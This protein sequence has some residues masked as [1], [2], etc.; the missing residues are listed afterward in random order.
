M[1]YTQDSLPVYSS[2]SVPLQTWASLPLQTQT[3]LDLPV[4]TDLSLQQ[5]TACSGPVPTAPVTSGAFDYGKLEYPVVQGQSPSGHQVPSGH[6]PEPGHRAEA[7][8]RPER[9]HASTSV[10]KPP[11]P[12]S[13]EGMSMSPEGLVS[14]E[15]HSET[16]VA[17][18]EEVGFGHATSS[19]RPMASAPD[20]ALKVQT[21]A[22]Q[23]FEHMMS[24]LYLPDAHQMYS[25]GT[26]QMQYSPEV[27]A[28]KQNVG[29]VVALDYI[30]Y[31]RQIGHE[32]MH[33]D[34]GI[35]NTHWNH[36]GPLLQFHDGNVWSGNSKDIEQEAALQK[37]D[38]GE[39]VDLR[40]LRVWKQGASASRRRGPDFETLNKLR[41]S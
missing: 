29:V 25:Y 23:E 6:R 41:N 40:G 28:Q 21:K 38:H 14:L 30:G 15:P 33:S 2:A 7:R 12:V 36:I 13:R 10:P 19:T 26:R 20:E 34:D 22:E 37:S 17:K 9:R 11:K 1:N 35:H 3:S 18:S 27:P 5:P 8:H 39:A 32:I 24:D 31:P 16:R 4:Y